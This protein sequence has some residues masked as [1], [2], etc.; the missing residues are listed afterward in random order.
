MEKYLKEIADE[1]KKI[2]LELQYSNEVG[3]LPPQ[4]VLPEGELYKTKKQVQQDKAKIAQQIADGIESDK[5]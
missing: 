4:E 2:R 1:L 5:W 3:K